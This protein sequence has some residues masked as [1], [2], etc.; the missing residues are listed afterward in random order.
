M[1]M[2]NYME[3]R[4]VTMTRRQANKAKSILDELV[5]TPP[6]PSSHFLS[7]REHS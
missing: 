3:W 7:E 4:K 6:L 2:E 5:R 1:A